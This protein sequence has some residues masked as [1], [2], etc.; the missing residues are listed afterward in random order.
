MIF[1]SIGEFTSRMNLS[2]SQLNVG[3]GRARKLQFARLL[4][5]VSRGISGNFHLQK[6]AVMKDFLFLWRI[7]F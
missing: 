3:I 7:L 6:T 2:H 1:T 5:N 4:L